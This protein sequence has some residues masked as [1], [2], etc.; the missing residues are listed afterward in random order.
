MA[1]DEPDGSFDACRSERMLQWV[2]DPALAIGE[3]VRVLRPGGRLSLID[4]DWRTLVCDVPDQGAM[5][6]LLDGLM[7][8]RGSSAA[9][10]SHLLNTCREA[11]LQHLHVAAATHT[12]TAWDPDT[13][14]APSGFFP[15]QTV[16]PQLADLGFI[17]HALGERLVTEILDAARRDRFFMSV[18]MFAVAGRVPEGR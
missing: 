4:T 7:R 9:V 16:I 1:I 15:F 6:E 11:G 13:D 5:Q 17:D 8:Q 10:G 14:P 12:W 18:T 2:D 3:M